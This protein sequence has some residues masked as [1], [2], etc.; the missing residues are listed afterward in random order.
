LDRIG[1]HA[2]DDT[3]T[4]VHLM[5][6][7]IETLTDDTL[8]AALAETPGPLVVD[9]HA[10]WCGPCRVLGPIVARLARE[11]P[12]VRVASVD[13]DEEPELAARFGVFS[14]P[15]VIRFDGGEETLRITG[16]LPYERLLE[17]L[18]VSP[19]ARSLAA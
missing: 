6:N 15:T 9:F 16:A 18:G 8:P 5:A 12:E 2:H 7:E 3:D 4:G 14:I 10:E 13:V 11:H 17:E 1:S 19:P